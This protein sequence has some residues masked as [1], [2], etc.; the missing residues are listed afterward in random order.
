MPVSYRGLG[1]M[2]P[3]D[4]TV[5]AAC[6]VACRAACCAVCYVMCVPQDGRTALRIAYNAEEPLEVW[7]LLERGAS[8]EGAG[9]VR[10]GGPWEGGGVERVP[11]C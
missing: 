6:R 4:D 2:C 3:M 10:F 7:Q 9:L 5:R 8:A 11:S 1:A